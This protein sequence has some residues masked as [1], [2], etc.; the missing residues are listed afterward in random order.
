[1]AHRDRVGDPP[2]RREVA[3]DVGHKRKSETAVR[4]SAFGGK[5]DVN[6]GPLDFRF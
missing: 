4:M 2:G 6:F 3:G 1:M 5:A